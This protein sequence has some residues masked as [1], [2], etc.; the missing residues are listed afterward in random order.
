MQR[1][2][3]Y[4][5]NDYQGICDD[6]HNLLSILTIISMILYSLVSL[7]LGVAL[8]HYFKFRFNQVINSFTFFSFI[9]SHYIEKMKDY[10]SMLIV[11]VV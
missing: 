2:N 4:Y 3:E 6:T 9:S 5:L 1:I 7:A 10:Y 11:D 8:N